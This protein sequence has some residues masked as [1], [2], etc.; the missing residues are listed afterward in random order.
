M[1][2][3]AKN[4]MMVVEKWSDDSKYSPP[5]P[6]PPLQLNWLHVLMQRGMSHRSKKERDHGEGFFQIH[7]L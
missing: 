5:P 3:E 7:S 2:N 1:V 6:P 4:G